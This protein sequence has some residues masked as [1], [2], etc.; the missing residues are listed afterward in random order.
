MSPQQPII[1][2][3]DSNI[4]MYFN[5][6]DFYLQKPATGFKELTTKKQNEIPEICKF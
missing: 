2:K 3:E 1:L 4:E 6:T 5:V